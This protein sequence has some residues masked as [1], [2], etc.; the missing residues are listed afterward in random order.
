MKITLEC[1][2]YPE[3]KPK[4]TGTYLVQYDRDT[5]WA[6]KIS[7]LTWKGEEWIFDDDKVIA[8]AE[9]PESLVE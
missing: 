2:P 3:V 9:M 4:Y 5:Q 7:T 1:H 6:D 8:W